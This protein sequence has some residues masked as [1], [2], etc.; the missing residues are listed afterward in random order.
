MRFGIEQAQQL[1]W[2]RDQFLEQLQLVHPTFPSET[3]A[4]EHLNILREHNRSLLS[5]LESQNGLGGKGPL[6]II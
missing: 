3:G 6:K 5:H 2:V 4:T 1:H